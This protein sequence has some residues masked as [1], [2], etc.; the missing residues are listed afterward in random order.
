[1]AYINKFL[2]RSIQF[3]NGL[4]VGF[5]WVHGN[6]STSK[7]SATL[8][9]YHH[10]DSITWRWALYWQ[11]PQSLLCLPRLT[12]WRPGGRKSRMGSYTLTLPLVGALSLSWQQHMFRKAEGEA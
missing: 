10:P 6:G 11:K 1:M 8:A 12:V 7:T 2:G 4:S 3:R 9:A 5:N